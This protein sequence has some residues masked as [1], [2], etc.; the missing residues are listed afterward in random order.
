MKTTS[1]EMAFI[2][3]DFM[4]EELKGM[5]RQEGTV[6]TLETLD[7]R[8]APLGLRLTQEECLALAEGRERALTDTVQVEFGEGIL[9][10]LAEALCDSPYLNPAD[11]AE[12]LMEGQLLFYHWKAEV[13]DLVPDRA[14][15]AFLRKAF[16]YVRGAMTYLEGFSLKELRERMEGGPWTM[17]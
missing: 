7:R 15:L 9:P 8:M 2:I 14:V 13:G 1:F 17:D 5:M 3:R 10:A 11:W 6:R 4:K 12:T 16:D